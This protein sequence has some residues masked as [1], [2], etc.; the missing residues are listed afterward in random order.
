MT[1]KKKTVFVTVGS[2]KFESLIET[3]LSKDTLRLLS[4]FNYQR[5]ILQAGN[6]EHSELSTEDSTRFVSQGID[7]ILYRL[8]SH[9]YCRHKFLFIKKLIMY[10]LIVTTMFRFK[11]CLTEDRNSADLVISHAGSASIIESLEA[12]KRLIVVVNKDLMD[13]HQIEIAKKMSDFGYLLFATPSELLV[14]IQRIENCELTFEP[15]KAG[16]PKLF[17]DYLKFG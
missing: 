8:I 17:G 16:N 11:S 15:Y 13:N 5:C 9:K 14:K 2:T 12:G 1:T 10:R 6:G 3:V 7:V 4:Q